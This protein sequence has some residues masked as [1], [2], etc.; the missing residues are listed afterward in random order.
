M[1]LF[2]SK[3]HNF[4]PQKVN[5]GDICL[6][7]MLCLEEIPMKFRSGSNEV[8]IRFLWKGRAKH[9]QTK[10]EDTKNRENKRDNLVDSKKSSI[11]AAYNLGE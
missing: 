7:Y 10:G 1:S 11:F 5:S 8:P 3:N 9:K 6:K 4:I 2:F